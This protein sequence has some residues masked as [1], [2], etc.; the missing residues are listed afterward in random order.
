MAYIPGL[1]SI[2]FRK[3]S[4]E[5]ILAAC[6]EVGLSWIE[7]GS[8]VHVPPTDFENAKR[9]AE[10]TR[11]A[12]MRCIDY[13][14]YF[15][16]GQTPIE[17]FAAYVQTAQILGA[18]V[19]RVWGGVKGSADMN[20]EERASLA[21]QA[22]F[23]AR[24]CADAGLVLATEWHCGTVTDSLDSAEKF[25]DEV[26]EDAL[27][28]LWQPS[29]FHEEAYNLQAAGA[30][31]YRTENLHVFQWDLHGRYPL[32]NGEEIWGKYLNVFREE[33]AKRDIGL[34]LEFMHD[35]RIETLAETAKTLHAWIEKAK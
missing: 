12:G 3:N 29:Q 7:W 14:S 18:K 24:A 30:V 9:V 16:L 22:K 8:D 32:A 6:Q 31:A 34:L 15:R 10:L 11:K 26:G 21:E 5:E 13:G 27:R 28:T 20:A 35:D 23:C 25:F 17:Q 2:S 4:V 1:V 19:I 33:A